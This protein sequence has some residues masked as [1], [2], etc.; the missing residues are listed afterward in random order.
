MNIILNILLNYIRSC[1]YLVAGSVITCRKCTSNV[2][3]SCQDE[4]RYRHNFGSEIKQSG[5]CMEAAWDRSSVV[6]RVY[7]TDVS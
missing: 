5:E 3:K 7:L 6:F 1:V 4:V 2:S